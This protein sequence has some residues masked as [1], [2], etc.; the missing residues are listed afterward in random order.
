MLR[1]DPSDDLLHAMLG[2]ELLSDRRWEEAATAFRQALKL[3]PLYSAG[4]RDL[5]KA[6]HLA[7]R[8][9]EAVLVLEEGIPVARER[10]D[11]QAVREMEV[12]LKRAREGGAEGE[13]R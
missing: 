6:L 13:G 10:G 8:Q 11:L 1:A 4:W 5:G 9:D 3:N 2:A 12:W 7:G